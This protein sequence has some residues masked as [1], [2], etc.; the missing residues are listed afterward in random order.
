MSFY[1]FISP[2]LFGF[3]LF[4]IMPIVWGF[5]TSLTNQMAF[6]VQRRFIGLDNYIKMLSD[7]EI[8]YAFLTTFIYTVSSTTLAVCWNMPAAFSASSATTNGLGR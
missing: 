8:W 7:P 5:S 1:I 4:Q 6:T 2:W 3:L